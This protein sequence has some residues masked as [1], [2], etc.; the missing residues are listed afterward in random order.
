MIKT[1]IEP[2][3]QNYFMK[4]FCAPGFEWYLKIPIMEKK[5][6]ERHLAVIENSDKKKEA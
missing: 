4:N 6:Y 5:A 1:R 3:V 2:D